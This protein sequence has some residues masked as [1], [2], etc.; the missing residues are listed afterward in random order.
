MRNLL[1][2]AAALAAVSVFVPTSSSLAQGVVV[3][4][5][6]VGVRVGEPRRWEERREERWGERR[7]W[8]EREVRG[9]RTITIQRDDGSMRRIRK[10]GDGD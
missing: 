10:C 5:P 4:G 9:C 3:E 8:R 1:I 6:G 7:R 2:S